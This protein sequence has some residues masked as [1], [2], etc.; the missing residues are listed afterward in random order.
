MRSAAEEQSFSRQS[1]H[2]RGDRIGDRILVKYW[3]ICKMWESEV[4][5]FQGV[6]FRGW[7]SQASDLETAGRVEKLDQGMPTV[8]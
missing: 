6:T 5:I 1:P 8:L 3:K 7:Y 2:D 4:S